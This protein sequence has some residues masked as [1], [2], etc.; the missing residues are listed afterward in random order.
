MLL[1]RLQGDERNEGWSLFFWVDRFLQK[2]SLLFPTWWYKTGYT[3]FASPAGEM[4]WWREWVGW[5]GNRFLLGLEV[6]IS[7]PMQERW[8]QS[9]GW[10][11]PL[12]KEMA[13]HSS[14]LA[15]EIPW[16]EDPG[17]LQSMRSQRVRYGWLNS[18]SYEL[19]G[20]WAGPYSSGIPCGPELDVLHILT[21]KRVSRLA[22]LF[23]SLLFVRSWVECLL[24]TPCI[25]LW[26]LRENGWP[27][28]QRKTALWSQWIH[29]WASSYMIENK[30][31]RHICIK[32]LR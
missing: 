24:D 4:C 17:E 27:S 8:V 10:E 31:V 12:E 18:K 7:L 3:H 26:K 11:D 23:V 25:F 22:G 2:D 16:T 32:C 5:V 29:C 28:Q 30:G 6:R 1:S 15:W 19:F 20:E 21:Q 13:T 9:L 14:F